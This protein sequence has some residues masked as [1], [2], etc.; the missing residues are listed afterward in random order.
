MQLF[1]E[2]G[3]RIEEGVRILSSE[4]EANRHRA[5]KAAA[6]VSSRADLIK[7]RQDETEKMLDRFRSLG[8]MAREL[9]TEISEATPSCLSRI[10]FSSFTI[11]ACMRIQ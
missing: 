10:P 11:H 2:C 4:L 5:E 8:E 1:T 6:I 3:G 7:N 9:N